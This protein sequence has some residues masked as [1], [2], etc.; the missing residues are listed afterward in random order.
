MKKS[1]TKSSIQKIIALF[2]K[3]TSFF[4]YDELDSNWISITFGNRASRYQY[5]VSILRS[6]NSYSIC[7]FRVSDVYHNDDTFSAICRY[8][9]DMYT[10]LAILDEFIQTYNH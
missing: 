7:L 5:S 2:A 10:S 9:A 3:R 1:F 8:A 4:Q 6:S